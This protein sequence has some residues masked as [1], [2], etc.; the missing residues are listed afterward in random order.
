MERE[1][2]SIQLILMR[3]GEAVRGGESDHSRSLTPHGIA[4]CESIGHQLTQNFTTPLKIVSS[5]AVR[6]K[7]TAEQLFKFLKDFTIV[8]DHEL[9]IVH[10]AP[11]FAKHLLRH[12]T[13][14]DPAVMVVGHNP[15]ISIFSSFLTG[16]H[17]SFGTSDCQI[18]KSN[19]TDWAVA[20]QSP[21]T[22]KQSQYLSP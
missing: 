13:P 11:M 1:D 6:T 9:Y 7:Q 14:A 2:A 19:E 22:W 20:L 8:H 4:D 15:S 3:H 16:E 17:T 18:L 5:D 10:D 12:V 21:E